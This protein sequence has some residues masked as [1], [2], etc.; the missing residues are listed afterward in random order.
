M[1]VGPKKAPAVDAAARPVI[2][3]QSGGSGGNTDYGTKAGS[4][5]RNPSAGASPESISPHGAVWDFW[6]G[7]KMKIV[8]RKL[9]L[10]M[11][12]YKAKLKHWDN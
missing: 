5:L 8:V 10:G 12:I 11:N 1:E 2:L 3:S 6:I 9:K 7:G 4:Q